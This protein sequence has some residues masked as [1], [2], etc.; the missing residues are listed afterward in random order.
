MMQCVTF[1]P[2]ASGA[3][4][5]CFTA[6]VFNNINFVQ[7]KLVMMH[8]F[9]DYSEIQVGVNYNLNKTFAIQKEVCACVCM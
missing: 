7:H 2:A 4:A 9:C 1:S 3:G 8:E 5:S 6:P